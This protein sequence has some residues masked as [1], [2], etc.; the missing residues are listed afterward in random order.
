MVLKKILIRKRAQEFFTKRNWGKAI[1]EYKKLVE[2]D[3]H[4]LRMHLRLGDLYRKL[5]KEKE[6]IDEYSFVA[7]AYA[8]DGYIIQA[9]SAYKLILKVNP[10]VRGIKE[11]IENLYLKR[12][13][14]EQSLVELS[15][16]DEEE[17]DSN[18]KDVKKGEIIKES[19]KIPISNKISKQEEELKLTKDVD[20][21]YEKGVEPIELTDEQLI[22]E[23]PMGLLLSSKEE[24]EKVLS[25]PISK[26]IEI[27]G[28]K[29]KTE[30]FDEKELLK[31]KIPLFSDLTKEEFMEV[32]NIL[33][34][35]QVIKGDVIVKE[36][37][38]G[39]SIYVI[40]GGEFEVLKFDPL[41]KKDLL[42]AKLK[43][44]DFFGEFGFFSNQKR[45]AT[46]KAIEDGE[47]LEIKKKEMEYIIQ[48]YPGISKVLI[49]FYKKRL[50]DTLLAFSPI[51]EEFEA[52]QRERLINKFKLIMFEKGSVIVKKGSPPDALYIIKSGEIT[53][54]DKD[55]KGDIKLINRLVPGDF[56]GD[57]PLV[58]ERPYPYTVLATE[59]STLLKLVKEDY[60]KVVKEFSFINDAIKDLIL[61]R[62]V[63]SK[64]KV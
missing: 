48:K 25:D 35:R 31:A 54:V 5:N 36:G 32:V 45:Y 52:E 43:P 39:D 13:E 10:K 41:K 46:V 30:S 3:P 34:V 17:K 19:Q 12:T 60:K 29:A 58:F 38:S 62:V 49:A 53:L 16:L 40:A 7:D 37:E 47:L 63:D 61:K 18:K 2:I 33:M 59:K 8:R 11:K 51:F 21:S 6:A 55:E 64:A 57:L 4:D 26:G 28:E 20:N 24:L 44:G 27:K 14:A 15:Y 42:L 9:I 22:A 1:K 56:L 50:V 23:Q